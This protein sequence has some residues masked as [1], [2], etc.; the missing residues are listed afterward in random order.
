MADRNNNNKIKHKNTQMGKLRVAKRGINSIKMNG[1]WHK[2]RYNFICCIF[3]LNVMK[4]W[5]MY[6]QHSS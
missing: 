1:A 6:L 2:S 5:I 4:H 3:K